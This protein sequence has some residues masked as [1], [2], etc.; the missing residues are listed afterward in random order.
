[1]TE[2]LSLLS[3]LDYSALMF[4]LLSWFAFEYINDF[5]ERGRQS[6]STL[7]AEMRRNWMLVM[8]EREIRIVDTAIM[9]GQLQAAAFFAS[10]SILGIGGCFALLGATDQILQIYQDLP[11]TN[12]ESRA[13]LE[14]KVLGLTCIFIYAFFK[15]G[16]AFRL[17]N[18]SSILIGAVPSNPDAPLEERQEKALQAAEMNIVASQHFTAGLRGIFMA[19]AFLGWFVGAIA[20]YCSTILILLVLIRRQYF[21]RARKILLD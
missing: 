13:I 19:L 6:T 10:A 3:Y 17:F 16:W 14:I 7:M 8:A 9:S 18:Y 4:F 1:M 12:S 2:I 11:V 15:F 5:G 21:S 20:L